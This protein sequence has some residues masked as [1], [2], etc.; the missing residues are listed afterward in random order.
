MLPW[1]GPVCLAVLL[2]LT[3]MLMLKSLIENYK[4]M[5]VI[6]VIIL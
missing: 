6:L 2:L 1:S 4:F 3:P 5:I